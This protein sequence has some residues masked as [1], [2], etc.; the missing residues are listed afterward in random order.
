[1]QILWYFTIICTPGTDKVVGLQ[2]EVE[3]FE[4]S[5][6]EVDGWRGF[7]LIGMLLRGSRA[8]ESAADPGCA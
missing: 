1:M 2:T 5:F 6:F 3:D 4:G 8:V 7:K